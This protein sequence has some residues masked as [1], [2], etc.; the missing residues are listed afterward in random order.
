MDRLRE[1]FDV[2]DDSEWK[3]IS[4]SINKVMDA[5]R[6]ARGPGGPGGFGGP[7]PAGPNNRNPGDP[8][9]GP[10]G[11]SELR[12]PPGGP[13]GFNQ[14]LSPEAEALRNA[15]DA[16]AASAELK[17]KLAEFK[18]ARLKKQTELENAQAALRQLLTVHQEAVA[19]IFGLL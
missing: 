11:P 8:Q 16:K 3:A 14:E 9:P 12:G 18:A 5:R 13:G 19:T 7:P 6:A 2:K 10:G 17:S 4:A 15:I 1:A